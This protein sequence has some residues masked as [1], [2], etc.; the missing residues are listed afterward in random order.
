MKLCINTNVSSDTQM[1]SIGSDEIEFTK[2]SLL[3]VFGNILK[4]NDIQK[5]LNAE[6]SEEH[7]ALVKKSVFVTLALFVIE[8]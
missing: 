5:L 1:F 6:P 4:Y 8:R 3:E 7:P 2:E